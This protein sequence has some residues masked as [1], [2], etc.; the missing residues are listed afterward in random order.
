MCVY[1]G[2]IYKN[3]TSESQ[4]N[5]DILEAAVLGTNQELAN[6]LTNGFWQDY[7]SSTR[8]FNLTS[9]GINAKNGVLTYNTTGD[10]IDN[11]GISSEQSFLVDE[12]FK[13]IESTLGIDF[14]KT[15][16]SNADIRF[17]DSSSGAYAYSVYDSGFISYSDVNISEN[18]NS[19]LNGFGNYTF[20]TVLHEIGHALGLGHQGDYNGLASYSNDAV[21]TNDSWQSS[22]MSY[23]NQNE[24]TSIDSSYAYLSTFSSV[25]WIALD[26]L[27]N[28]QGFSLSNSFSGDTIYGFNTNISLSTS[29][30]FSELTNWID[31]TA[32][33]ISDGN[34]NDT[35]DFSG[36]SNNQTIDLRSTDKSASSLFTSNIAGLRGNLVIAAGTTIENAIG[37]SGNDTITGNSSNNN[38]NGGGGN[39]SL[40]GGLGDDT[41]VVDSIADDVIENQNE[42]KD[43]ILTSISFT[44]PNNVENIILTGSSDIDA[45]GNNLDNTLIGNSGTNKIDGA[46]GM[47]KV[48]FD[49]LFTYYSLSLSNGNLVIQDDRSGSPNGIKTLEN[50]EIAEFSDST[51][52]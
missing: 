45:T 35:L 21:Y 5:S 37:G 26:D 6:Y 30:I 19:G 42:G 14:Q 23:F 34:G 28:P 38:L 25:D 4:K 36:F 48:I 1:C 40:I 43:L 51:K 24:N 12:G 47:D 44:L 3:H 18:W 52:Q 39:D 31:S 11:N 33:T 13:L 10:G 8:K 7:G 15:T 2:N 49:G 16:N 32:F 29:Q 41:Y 27:Y 46:L 17:S 9:S 22:I 20:Q 50:I